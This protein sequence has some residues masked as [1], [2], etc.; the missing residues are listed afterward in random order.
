M[1]TILYQHLSQNH[2]GDSN[3]K[4]GPTIRFRLPQG[5]RM[6]IAPNSTTNRHPAG[7]PTR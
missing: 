1:K 6:F 2:H 3:E 4:L 7:K 5:A